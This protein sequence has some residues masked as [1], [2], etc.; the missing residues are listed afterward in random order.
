MNTLKI[1]SV[2][3]IALFSQPAFSNEHPLLEKIYSVKDQRFI[4][5]AALKSDI[6]SH[7]IVMLGETHDNARHH[8]LQQTVLFWLL[9]A[10][11]RPKLVVEMLNLNQ[12]QAINLSMN[13]NQLNSEALDKQWQWSKRGWDNW[14]DYYPIFNTAI[15][16]SLT[17][18]ADNYDNEIIRNMGMKGIDARPTNH[19]AI[20]KPLSTTAQ[21]ALINGI[22]E[23]HC[24]MMPEKMLPNMLLIQTSRDQL[25]AAKV[26]KLPM[27]TFVLAGSEHIRTDRGIPHFLTNAQ[28][29]S[30]ISIGLIEIADEWQTPSSYQKLWHRADIPHDYLWFTERVERP[31]LCESLRKH[32]AKKKAKKH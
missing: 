3:L 30:S 7:K 1:V 26:S 5:Q 24:N 16:H 21:Q 6:L 12:Q 2:I 11:R 31:D 20:D 18:L 10:N 29:K 32:F 13:Q 28:K 27:D 25:M 22:K 4:S 17:I 9:K 14:G 8:T 19:P 23:S 15:S